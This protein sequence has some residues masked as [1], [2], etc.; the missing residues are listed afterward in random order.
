MTLYLC[1]YLCIL[2]YHT[3]PPLLLPSWFAVRAD[4]DRLRK[5]NRQIAARCSPSID[6]PEASVIPKE[7]RP[8]GVI[9]ASIRRRICV[10][11]GNR[12]TGL[13]V[14]WSAACQARR[15]TARLNDWITAPL[16]SEPTTCLWCPVQA[17]VGQ[18]AMKSRKN[19]SCVSSTM[20]N[21][22]RAWIRSVA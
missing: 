20:S 6:D 5:Q 15:L 12:T 18:R 8:D 17:E 2:S 13:P 21:T 16:V 4:A 22:S 9:L 19:S 7:Q 3:L 10:T 14:D 1:K 11:E